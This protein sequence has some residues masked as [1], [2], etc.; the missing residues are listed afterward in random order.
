VK[1]DGVT[2]AADFWFSGQALHSVHSHGVSSGQLITVLR[3][4][5]KGR[6]LAIS[7]GAFLSP[8]QV[9]ASGFVDDNPTSQQMLFSHFTSTCVVAR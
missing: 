3:G 1:H 9:A 7:V 5:R 6:K 4:V 2:S 8:I